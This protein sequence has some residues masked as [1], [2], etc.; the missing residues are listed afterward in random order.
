[1]YD[2]LDKV[3]KDWQEGKISSLSTSKDVVMK[4]E[5]EAI[6]NEES[7]NIPKKIKISENLNEDNTECSNE[8]ENS[9]NT[10]LVTENNRFFRT[11]INTSVTTQVKTENYSSNGEI[12]FHI[13]PTTTKKS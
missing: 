9:Y 8:F 7:S 5:F 6:K 3:L 10:S 13:N 12:T 4:Q 1:M 11:P 2:E